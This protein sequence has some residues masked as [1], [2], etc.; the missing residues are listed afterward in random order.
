MLKASKLKILSIKCLCLLRNL[1]AAHDPD[2]IYN[3]DETCLFYRLTPSS[4]LATSEV[5]G[6]K[7]SKERLT[8]MC[9]ANATGTH[10]MKLLL[11]GKSA[12]PRAFGRTWNLNL[13]VKYRHN[14]KAWMTGALFLAWLE[15]FNAEMAVRKKKAILLRV[16]GDASS[17]RHLYQTR[18]QAGKQ[19]PYKFLLHPLLSAEPDLNP[20]TNG[21]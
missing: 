13:Y 20:A 4:T 15:A 12:R 2:C 21:A 9:C 16:L 7:K 17:H 11:I 14:A 19:I 5:R 8:V 6:K 10:K 1:L 3:A 18:I